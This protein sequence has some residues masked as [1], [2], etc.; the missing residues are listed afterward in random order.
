L[1]IARFQN[2]VDTG[3]EY[4]RYVEALPDMTMAIKL[5]T[6]LSQADPQKVA[7]MLAIQKIY[8]RAGSVW[9]FIISADKWYKGSGSLYC[10][11]VIDS[12]SPNKGLD[13]AMRDFCEKLSEDYPRI[14]RMETFASGNY[15]LSENDILSVIWSSAAENIKELK[16]LSK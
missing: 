2:L 14:P 12:N 9:N 11:V 5:Y 16:S 7:L 10:P 8:I 13:K 4:R 15:V 1:A 3:V 6:D